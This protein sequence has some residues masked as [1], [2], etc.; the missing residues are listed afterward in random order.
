MCRV[1]SSVVSSVVLAVLWVVPVWS[2]VVVVVSP[3][4]WVQG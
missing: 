4:V 3:V 1:V 2:V